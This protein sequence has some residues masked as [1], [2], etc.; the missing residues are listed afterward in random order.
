MKRYRNVRI[1]T[2]FPEE[3]MLDMNL[4]QTAAYDHL[5]AGSVEDVQEHV[6]VEG[7]LPEN[8]LEEIPDADE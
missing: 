1:D 5:S 2:G 8:G 4:P 7:M 6:L 3:E